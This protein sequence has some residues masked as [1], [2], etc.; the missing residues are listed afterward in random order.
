MCCELGN[1]FRNQLFGTKAKHKIKSAFTIHVSLKRCF[2][3]FVTTFPPAPVEKTQPEPSLHPDLLPPFQMWHHWPSQ[4]SW[5]PGTRGHGT[6]TGGTRSSLASPGKSTEHRAL[7]AG[8][9]SG[10][11]ATLEELQSLRIFIFCRE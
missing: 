4:G 10:H 8:Q 1:G 9:G 5:W 2:N 6:G 11:S 3:C 7:V